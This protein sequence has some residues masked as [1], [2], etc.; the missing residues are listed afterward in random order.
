M[1]YYYAQIDMSGKCVGVIDTHAEIVA[2][3]MIAIASCDPSYI[4]RVYSGGVWL[5]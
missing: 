3:H 1:R 4:G 5:D 2:I